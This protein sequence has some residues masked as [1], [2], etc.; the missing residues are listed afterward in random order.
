MCVYL[1]SGLYFLFVDLRS[2]DSIN[3]LFLN[4]FYK[5]AQ[6]VLSDILQSSCLSLQSISNM[7]SSNSAISHI[8]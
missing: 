4:L 3:I 6:S 8:E 5:T 2:D 7:N 1:I